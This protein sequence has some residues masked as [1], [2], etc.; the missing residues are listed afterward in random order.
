MLVNYD[1]D[2]LVTIAHGDFPKDNEPYTALSGKRGN[3]VALLGAILTEQQERNLPKEGF[4]ITM[5]CGYE[6]SFGES[7]DI[8]MED[9]PCPC[10]KPERFLIKLDKN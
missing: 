4:T 7:G 6:Q 9:L 1:V 2:K 10:G 5:P 8:P 3:I